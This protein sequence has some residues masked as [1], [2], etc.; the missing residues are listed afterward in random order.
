M[1][2]AELIGSIKNGCGV[3]RPNDQ[4][5]KAKHP[6]IR[7]YFRMPD[8]PETT[9]AGQ[10]ME[11]AGWTRRA[12]WH[13]PTLWVKVEAVEDEEHYIADRTAKFEEWKR[14]RDDMRCSDFL[15]RQDKEREEDREEEEPEGEL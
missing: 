3:F 7:G 4:K 15:A 8:K 1:T 6:D 12:T 5:T 11:L 10:L 2:L 14:K 13:K 9:K